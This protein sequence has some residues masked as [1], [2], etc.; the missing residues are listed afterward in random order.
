MEKAPTKPT[1]RYC[2]LLPI[3]GRA[4]CSSRRWEHA[5]LKWASTARLCCCEE[6]KRRPRLGSVFHCLSK[7]RE[8]GNERANLLLDSFPWRCKERDT[9]FSVTRSWMR[10]M[11]EQGETQ[12]PP[13]LYGLPITLGNCA[14]ETFRNVVKVP[15]INSSKHSPNPR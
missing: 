5:C 11:A 12:S 8:Q 3:H 9:S 13:P 15:P 7:A 10:S 1:S 4:F 14:R 6:L 2:A